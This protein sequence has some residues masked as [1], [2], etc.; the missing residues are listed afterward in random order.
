MQRR[1]PGKEETPRTP[2]EEGHCCC[3]WYSYGTGCLR[4]CYRETD[5]R[6]VYL[7]ANENYWLGV[8]DVPEIILSKAE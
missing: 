6:T 2:A 8:T 4:L 7:D 3:G 1:W 5:L